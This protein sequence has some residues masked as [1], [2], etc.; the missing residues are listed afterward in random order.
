VRA[1]R[2]LYN[3]GETSAYSFIKGMV[4]AEFGILRRRIPKRSAKKVSIILG[5]EI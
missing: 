3:A 1:G 4:N 2:I 5:M